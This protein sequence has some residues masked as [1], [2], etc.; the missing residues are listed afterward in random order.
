MKRHK[1]QESN[2]PVQR[3][4]PARQETNSVEVTDPEDGRPTNG[5]TQCGYP[6]I[7]VAADHSG[8]TVH[9]AG[10]TGWLANVRRVAGV[11]RRSRLRCEEKALKGR[12]P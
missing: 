7:E 5:P 6:E 3:L 4:I 9:A 8:S 10:D 12:T 1:P 11:E 2:E